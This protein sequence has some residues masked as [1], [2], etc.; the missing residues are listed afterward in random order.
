MSW[1]KRKP[2]PKNAPSA[3]PPKHTSPSAEKHLKEIKKIIR[4]SP[5]KNKKP[6]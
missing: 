3:P 6:N 5:S 2:R 1:Y 4:G